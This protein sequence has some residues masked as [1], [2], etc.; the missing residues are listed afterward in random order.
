MSQQA[1]DVSKRVS[2]LTSF[3]LADAQLWCRF[4]YREKRCSEVQAEELL[5]RRWYVGELGRGRA[6]VGRL[7]SCRARFPKTFSRRRAGASRTLF[8]IR[9]VIHVD[10]DG[11]TGQS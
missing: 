6:D 10:M 2:H 9:H 11:R 5:G 3:M 8:R 7:V 1:C 4:Q